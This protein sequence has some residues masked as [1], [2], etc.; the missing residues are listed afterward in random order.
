MERLDIPYFN[1]FS[2]ESIQP[3]GISRRIRS[4]RAKEK[5]A[6]KRFERS[7]SAYQALIASDTYAPIREDAMRTLSEC[8]N[9]L[10]RHAAECKDCCHLSAFMAARIEFIR[11]ILLQP[12]Q[13]VLED[14]LKRKAE[15][16]VS[17]VAG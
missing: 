6:K 14:D 11:E 7:V 9:E 2:P 16:S 4:N 3:E 1:P 5:D 12:V 17:E 15:E 13:A 10:I 8:V